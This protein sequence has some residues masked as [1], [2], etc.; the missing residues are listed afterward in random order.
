MVDSRLL[1]VILNKTGQDEIDTTSYYSYEALKAE[2]SE[3][4]V[5]DDV[6]NA[7][8]PEEPA[9]VVPRPGKTAWREELPEDEG[10]PPSFDAPALTTPKD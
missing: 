1:G 3:F 4:P 2:P 6:L 8:P 7:P 9:P 10:L 5:T